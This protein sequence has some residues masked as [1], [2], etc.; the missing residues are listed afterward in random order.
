MNLIGSIKIYKREIPILLYK[1]GTWYHLIFVLV[2]K[3]YETGSTPN[4]YNPNLQIRVQGTNTY[5]PADVITV[6]TFAGSSISFVPSVYFPGSG[7]WNTAGNVGIGTTAPTQQLALGGTVGGFGMSTADGSD[8]AILQISGGGAAA[9]TR[10]AYI[11]LYGN[12]YSPAG[13]LDLIPGNAGTS[14]IRFLNRA[15][16]A[17]AMVV[18]DT[19]VGIGTASPTLGKL[20]IASGNAVFDSAFFSADGNGI[21]FSPDST[22]IVAGVIPYG[23]G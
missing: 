15:G 22:N 1:R 7:I 14:I 2:Q 4:F 19:N 8:N 11:N 10:G 9:N 13:W 18:N 23:L 3:K 5:L 6:A 21:K 16:S 20:Q 12:E 17:A